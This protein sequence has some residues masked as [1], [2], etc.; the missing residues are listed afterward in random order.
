MA[1]VGSLEAG[2]TGNHQT[3]LAKSSLDG[4]FSTIFASALGIGTAFSAL[5]ILIYQGSI[6]LLASYLKDIMSPE[7]INE[8]SAVGGILIIAIGL[9]LL[10]V[11]KIKVGNMLP[12]IFIPLIYFL[13][14]NF[15]GIAI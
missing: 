9:N 8:M 2:L 4:I 14:T 1:I 12:A 3:L 15:A 11:K 6:T 10:K 5:P 13:I 7:I